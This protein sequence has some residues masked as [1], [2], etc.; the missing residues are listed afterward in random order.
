MSFQQLT[1]YDILSIFLM[2]EQHCGAQSP[3]HAYINTLPQNFSTPAYWS[4]ETL[5]SLPFDIC[6]DARLL[7]D[8]VTKNFSRLQDLFSHIATTLGDSVDGAFTFSRFTWALTSVSTR[9]VFMRPPNF[10]GGSSDDNCI[11]LA[12]L[13]D[14][15]NHSPNVQV[16]STWLVFKIDFCSVRMS[17]LRVA[18]V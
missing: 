14:L 18:K 1:S 6:Q 12:P 8:K 2:Y 16:L 3:W 15:L 4:A 17:P 9:C 13:L 11:A 5:L 10:I 7:V